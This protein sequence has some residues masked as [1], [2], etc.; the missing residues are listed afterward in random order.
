MY[1]QAAALVLGFSL[2]TRLDSSKSRHLPWN[3]WREGSK[4][5]EVWQVF[6]KEW[7]GRRDSNSRPL[8]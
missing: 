6:E 1:I 2:H 7:R 8:P 5:F 3:E 4:P